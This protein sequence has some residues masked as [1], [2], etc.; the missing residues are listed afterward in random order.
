MAD[1]KYQAVHRHTRKTSSS[2]RTQRLAAVVIGAALLAIS[3]GAVAL[4]DRP[5]PQ[6]PVTTV[7]AAVSKYT[8]ALLQ[9]RPE[10]REPVVQEPIV[11]EPALVTQDQLTRALS[12]ITPYADPAARIA[13]LEAQIAEL[14][15]QLVTLAEQYDGLSE[16]VATLQTLI[17]D[18]NTRLTSLETPPEP[19]IETAPMAQEPEITP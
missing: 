17:D 14:E 8:R 13:E 9:P 18:L 10:V 2:K 11:S 6:E 7:M 5:E 4:T 12:G 19:P 1:Q 3:G 16:T 15:A